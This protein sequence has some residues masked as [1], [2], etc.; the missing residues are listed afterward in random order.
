MADTL[1]SND[2]K[3]TD[4]AK[5]L[6]YIALNIARRN[7]FG[8]SL[9]ET[10][11]LRRPGDEDQYYKKSLENI[12]GD[13]PEGEPKSNLFKML[14][15][16]AE[17]ILKHP[18]E[19][20][21]KDGT[22]EISD[23]L[24]VEA[25]KSIKD[26][27]I[28]KESRLGALSDLVKAERD[29]T[30]FAF[31]RN[32]FNDPI[33]KD[34]TLGRM[35]IAYGGTYFHGHRK[36]NDAVDNLN[37]ALRES[38]KKDNDSPFNPDS[39]GYIFASTYFEV[40]GKNYPT[41]DH[42]NTKAVQQAVRDVALTAARDATW[43]ALIKDIKEEPKVEVKPGSAPVAVATK[44][45]D[46]FEMPKE[47]APVTA[48]K[49]KPPEVEKPVAPEK[50]SEPDIAVLS[51]RGYADAYQARGISHDF[52][53]DKDQFDKFMQNVHGRD[54][55]K[56]EV[57]RFGMPNVH[58]KGEHNE[59]HN[60]AGD[61]C[62]VSDGHHRFHKVTSFDEHGKPDKM[63]AQ[64][65]TAEEMVYAVMTADKNG[66]GHTVDQTQTLSFAQRLDLRKTLSLENEGDTHIPDSQVKG[67]Q[68]FTANAADKS[69]G[70]THVAFTKEQTN[71]VGGKIL[72][73]GAS[74]DLAAVFTQK[75]ALTAIAAPAP[76]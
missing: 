53:H 15:S 29:L 6:A 13:M 45:S 69:Y 3:L 10:D 24:A 2:K 58:G 4:V 28:E 68:V 47:I 21:M 11:W 54:T 31:H 42:N 59:E 76:L 37:A 65:L 46:D 25:N 19:S 75:P 26:F 9:G 32:N 56:G 51:V 18:N 30:N 71:G 20:A 61:L 17:N 49:S 74:P 57:I 39:A 16:T 33:D 14:E 1:V 38:G 63:S 12:L 40:R 35:E 62:Y 44:M 50:L 72:P 67:V 60:R 22:K 36:L 43:K 8:S 70:D 55:T 52:L 73:A 7:H 64:G 5:D 34:G 41:G 23:Y 66:F 48:I 27:V